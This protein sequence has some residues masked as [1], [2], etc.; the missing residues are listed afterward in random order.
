MEVINEAIKLFVPVRVRKSFGPHKPLWWNSN[1]QRVRKRRIKWWNRYKE[2]HLREDFHKYK[3]AEKEA[4]YLVRK[5]KRELEKKIASNIKVDS[6]F[7]WKYARSLTKVKSSIGPLTDSKGN[8]ITDDLQT[9][10]EF[11]EYFSSLFTKETLDHIPEPKK[12]FNEDEEN[13]L[14]DVDIT[15]GIVQKKLL[16]L[17]PN[18]S[19]VGGLNPALLKEC[20]KELAKPLSIIFRTSL[21]NNSVPKIWKFANV[22]PIF[23]KGSRSLASNYRPVSLT[24]IVCRML[25]SI[26]VD[27]IRSHLSKYKLILETQHGFVSKKS[28]LSNLLV[29]L[30]EVTSLVDQGY[31]VDAIYLDFS[32]AFE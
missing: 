10:E 1:I 4:S 9:A 21:S 19:A 22:T 13:F 30:E 17:N 26:L 27:E 29:Y 18:K 25:E 23:K 24:S 28:C 8:V 14:K 31:P 2:T 7:F 12:M 6:K 3:N 15:E 5:A 11:N 16:K 32:K 20:A